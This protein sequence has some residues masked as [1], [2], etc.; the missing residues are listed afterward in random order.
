MH[1]W[2]VRILLNIAALIAG[3]AVGAA[4]MIA[5]GSPL[6]LVFGVL[7]YFFLAWGLA[8][9]A[10]RGPAQVG[11]IPYLGPLLI[12]YWSLAALAA[13]G[14]ATFFAAVTA[15][16]EAPDMLSGLWTV[17]TSLDILYAIGG[18]LLAA[19][20]ILIPPVVAI[21]D[22][23]PPDDGG[24]QNVVPAAVVSPP[25]SQ[26]SDFNAPSIQLGLPQAAPLPATVTPAPVRGN[27]LEELFGLEPSRES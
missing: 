13:I 8:I 20:A 18:S 1:Y 7:I 25:I 9:Q 27:T 6:F 22:R 26:L 24:S 15:N 12:V 4:G 11:M 2:L 23:G 14:A 3:G 21:T 19:L 16:P 10:T 17:L 5:T